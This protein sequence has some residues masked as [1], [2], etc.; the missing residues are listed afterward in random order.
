L[1]HGPLVDVPR[2]DKIR[3]DRECA[4][5]PG[6]PFAVITVHFSQQQHTRADRTLAFGALQPAFGP[7]RSFH[8]QMPSN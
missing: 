2:H 7:R 6:K 8:A 5:R 1:S 3:A 4:Q